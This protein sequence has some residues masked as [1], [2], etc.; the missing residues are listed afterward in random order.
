MIQVSNT[1]HT[2]L[3]EEV[4]IIAN[5][6]KE[7]LNY[8]RVPFCKL[9][10]IP[11]PFEAILFTEKAYDQVSHENKTPYRIYGACMFST[12]KIGEDTH[13]NLEW[14]WFH[15]FF[16]HRGKLQENWDTLKSLFG[17]FS[18]NK[19]ISNDMQSFLEKRNDNHELVGLHI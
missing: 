6:F 13:W 15:P 14:I 17:D 10:M 1:N 9:G 16:R 4:Y 5:Y 12:L 2:E 19:P 3:Y 18:I 11:E 7:E 8:N